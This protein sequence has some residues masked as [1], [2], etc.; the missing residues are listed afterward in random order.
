MESRTLLSGTPNIDVF[1]VPTFSSNPTEIV[2]GPDGDLWFSESS[3]Q[4]GRISPQGQVVEFPLP[5]TAAGSLP[6]ITGLAAGSDGAVWALD[7]ANAQVDRIGHDGQVRSFAVPGVTPPSGG[8]TAGNVNPLPTSLSG[9]IVDGPDGNLW[10]S[11]VSPAAGPPPPGSTTM[12]TVSFRQACKF[13]I[14]P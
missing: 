6:N 4:I 10:F 3:G 11:L 5:V 14:F 2:K 13:C 1:A 9:Q 7:V 12:S 8:G